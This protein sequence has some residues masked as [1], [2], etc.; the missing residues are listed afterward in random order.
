M[1]RGLILALWK[2]SIKFYSRAVRL[3]RFVVRQ[4]VF[5]RLAIHHLDV[6]LSEADDVDPVTAGIDEFNLCGSSLPAA[7]DQHR[8]QAYG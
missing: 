2:V 8:H 6:V 7:H 1:G 5:L 4:H 3:H